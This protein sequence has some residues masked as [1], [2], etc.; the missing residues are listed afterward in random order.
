MEIGQKQKGSKMKARL[1]LIVLVVVAIVGLTLTASADEV[2]DKILSDLD[3]QIAGYVNNVN[4]LNG[5]IEQ[6]MAQL[7]QMRVQ[8]DQFI[9][10]KYGAEQAKQKVL[11][12]IKEV[13]ENV[14]EAL[15]DTTPVLHD[16][17]ENEKE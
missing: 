7:G 4:A 9:G 16:S 14:D 15:T 12:S 8:R 2:T 17:E 10:A 1:F 6:G 3:A 13:K 5:N 11:D